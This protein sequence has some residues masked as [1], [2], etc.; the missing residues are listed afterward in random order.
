L[1]RIDKEQL[2][3]LGGLMDAFSHQ[4]VVPSILRGLAPAVAWADNA[5]SPE[6]AV[7]WDLVNGLVFCSARSL[8]VATSKR[9]VEFLRDD[10]VPRAEA[11]G[12]VPFQLEALPDSILAVVRDGLPEKPSSEESLLLYSRAPD[13]GPTA[14]SVPSETAGDFE[15]VP[16]TEE[17]LL[18]DLENMDEIRSC[19]DA[20][21]RDRARY[22][23]EGIGYCAV[24]E[25]AASAWCSTDYLVD[26]S[27]DLYVETFEPYGRRGLGTWVATSCINACLE[28]RHVV[29]WHC[30]SHNT[31]SRVVAE[32]SGLSLVSATPA[33]Q[34]G[35]AD[36]P[37]VTDS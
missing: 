33:L 31:G 2:G 25:R 17:L 28:A 1:V 18:S 37:D 12:Y 20:C 22:I 21:W 29:H 36:D 26:G 6:V 5:V 4:L 14:L 15:V 23:E 16:L 30:W 7:V 34:I 27:A 19:V 13:A 24:N 8:E 9:L 3:V 10:F 35:A 11:K 32:R